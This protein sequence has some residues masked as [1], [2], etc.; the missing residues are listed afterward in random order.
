[1]AKESAIYIEKVT[2]LPEEKAL[3]DQT[4]VNRFNFEGNQPLTEGLTYILLP[5]KNFAVEFQME[6]RPLPPSQRFWAVG[7]N[8]DGEAEE[9]RSIGASTV[10]AM[11][12]GWVDSDPKPTVGTR[13][14]ED[15]SLGLQSGLNWVYAMGRPSAS[16]FIKGEN[17]RL[18]IKNP[19]AIEFTGNRE[20]Y[21]VDFV[22]RQIHIGEDGNVII[23]TRSLKT[24]ERLDEPTE[25]QVKTAEAAL[26]AQKIKLS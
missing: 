8:E 12:L 16:H 23:V 25:D 17:S 13:Q 2:V 22:D 14:K 15:G 20:A 1:M 10:S 5:Q 19:T 26:K 9:I 7:I 4:V 3:V 6:G 24:F 18:V 21:T 11:G